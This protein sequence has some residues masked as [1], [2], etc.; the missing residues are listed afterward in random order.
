MSDE[1]D[2]IDD[3]GFDVPEGHRSGFVAIVGRPSVGKST[4]L[5]ALMRQK[6]AIVSPR[7]QTTRARQLGIITEETYQ[8][9]LMDTP[10][11]IRQTRHR[12]DEL[13]V[14]AA[15][16]TLDDADAI[17][18]LVD[19]S[20]APGAADRYLAE[21]LG[22]RSEQKP[23][24]LVLNKIDLVPEAARDEVTTAYAALL[25]AG[26]PIA[27][28]ALKDDGVSG[29]LDQVVAALPE[30]PRYYPP[31]QIT[32]VFV[33]DIAAE[34]IREQLMLQL[35]D[36]IPYGTAVRVQEFKERPDGTNYINAD[37]Y[38]D[39]ENHKGMIIGK[40]GA[41]LRS[42][43]A[44]A[45]EEIEKLVDGPVYLDLYVVVEPNWRRDERLL[46]Q[47]GYDSRNQ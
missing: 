9:V 24:F 26:R 15:L 5:N 23:V 22:P 30:G 38:V 39:R 1:Q 19:A 29:L 18:W 33:R 28:S 7:P 14:A 42:I 27:L 10:G 3:A 46:R 32:D 40:K 37:I 36:E 17:L 45:R 2:V 8:I 44:A 20:E 31:D 41:Q 12:L 21:T 47:F 16:D 43:G 4:L 34:L 11:I 13:M 35:E 6:I 25:P